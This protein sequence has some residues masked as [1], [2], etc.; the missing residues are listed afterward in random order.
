MVKSLF[1]RTKYDPVLLTF[2]NSECFVSL[3]LLHAF[4]HYLLIFFGYLPKALVASWDLKLCMTVQAGCMALI[5]F[6]KFRL[7]QVVMSCSLYFLHAVFIPLFFFPISNLSLCAYV[8][9]DLRWTW[10]SSLCWITENTSLVVKGPE[11]VCIS[12]AKAWFVE[13][14]LVLC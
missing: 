7:Q 10:G 14:V 4:S 13:Q 12:E 8:L 5:L 9:D 1:P 11:L 2:L 3:S 6:Q